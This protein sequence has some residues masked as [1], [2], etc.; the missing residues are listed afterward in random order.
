M[1]TRV[2]WEVKAVCVRDANPIT[3][4]KSMWLRKNIVTNA[5]SSMRVEAL[6]RYLLIGKNIKTLFER[7]WDFPCHTQNSGNSH[8]GRIV[9]KISKTVCLVIVS[10]GLSWV[11]FLGDTAPKQLKH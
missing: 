8:S 5:I 2:I 11:R 9:G 3:T 1:G 10:N 7:A 4:D 6:Q